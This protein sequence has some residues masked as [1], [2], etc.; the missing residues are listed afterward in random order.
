MAATNCHCE[1]RSDVAIVHHVGAKLVGERSRNIPDH[2]FP[3]PGSLLTEQ[4]RGRIPG[5]VVAIEQPAPVGTVL[6]HDPHRL[7]QSAGEMRDRRIDRHDQVQQRDQRRRVGEVAAVPRRDRPAA[8]GPP[9]SRAA[10]AGSPSAARATRSR[11]TTAQAA[12]SRSAATA[13]ECVA[14][15]TRPRPIRGHDARTE[16]PLPRRKPLRRRVQIRHLRRHGIEH[17]AEHQ[18]RLSSGVTMSAARLR[19]AQRDDPA[20]P[21]RASASAPS[22]RRRSARVTRAPCAAS[23]GA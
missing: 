19:L 12:A 6:Q 22:V 20:R 15:P 2:P 3:I 9:A 1:K 10:P 16:P 11:D 13:W 18:G 23:S 21:R 4:A 17:G 7:A 14:S 5:A 8:G